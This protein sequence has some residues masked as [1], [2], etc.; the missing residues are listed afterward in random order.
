VVDKVEGALK[1]P[2]LGEERLHG[3]PKP[4]KARGPKLH[5]QPSL[6]LVRK[7][8]RKALKNSQFAALS[9]NLQ[10]IEA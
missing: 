4:L 10:K 7:G 9:V 6:A 5:D 8:F 3:I 1:G 2:E